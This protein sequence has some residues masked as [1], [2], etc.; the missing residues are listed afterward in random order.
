MS[1]YDIFNVNIFNKEWIRVKIV[2]NN[3]RILSTSYLSIYSRWKITS[4][5]FTSFGS[6][7]RIN[8]T[9]E[10]VLNFSLMPRN[11]TFTFCT[12]NYFS[13]LD[14]I[15]V[16]CFIFVLHFTKTRRLNRTIRR[17]KRTFH[18]F[19]NFGWIVLCTIFKSG[20]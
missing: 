20:L 2:L 6:L 7:N 9:K 8:K 19:S 15:I 13:F 5:I 10:R 1:L 17:C 16:Y 11:F 3:R 14:E 12:Y 4:D 18:G